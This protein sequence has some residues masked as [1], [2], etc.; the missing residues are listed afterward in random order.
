MSFRLKTE[1]VTCNGLWCEIF[2]KRKLWKMDP[3]RWRESAISFS[4][5]PCDIASLY[6]K[7]LYG[8]HICHIRERRPFF[9]LFLI[10]DKTKLLSTQC[11]SNIQRGY[12]YCVPFLFILLPYLPA[13]FCFSQTSSEDHRINGKEIDN[14]K[15]EL[16]FHETTKNFDKLPIQ[17][18]VSS[19]YFSYHKLRFN[20]FKIKVMSYAF[21]K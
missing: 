16:L 3:Y 14:P 7:S 9:F 21:Q 6:V 5:W 8:C 10:F 2:W 17:Y 4:I 1:D 12:L 18:R 20:A 13:T 15:I 19:C 11:Q